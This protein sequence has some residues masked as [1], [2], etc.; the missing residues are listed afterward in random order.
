MF[1]WSRDI[2]LRPVWLHDK[3]MDLRS[4]NAKVVMI[5]KPLLCK[6]IGCGFYMMATLVFNKLRSAFWTN[7][8][9]VP[10]GL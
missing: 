3:K 6:S 1:I 10:L 4:L 5:Q 2:S 8:A 9:V 7:V